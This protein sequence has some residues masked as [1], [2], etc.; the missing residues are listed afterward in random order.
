MGW[1]IFSDA[2]GLWY[3]ELLSDNSDTILECARGFKTREHCVANAREHGFAGQ[4]S[5]P[6]DQGDAHDQEW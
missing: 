6:I 1:M 2:G 3:W 5:G 4:H